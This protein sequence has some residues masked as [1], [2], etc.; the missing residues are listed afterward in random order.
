MS[1]N[2]FEN[3]LNS[4]DYVV[5]PELIA[6]APASPRDSA[7][8]LVYNRKEDKISYDT[9]LNLAKFLPKGAVLVFNETKVIPA[10]FEAMKES[11]GKVRI[12]YISSEDNLSSMN[13]T[14]FERQAN[15]PE[16]TTGGEG[17]PHRNRGQL[18]CL[19]TKSRKN[20][21]IKVMADR[22]MSV[23]SKV[24]IN[25][26]I[27]FTA[28]KQEGKYYFL[29]PS[30]PLN[31]L[32]KV[33]EKYGQAPLPPYIK[34]SPLGKKGLKE[35]YQA[36]FARRNGSVAAPTASLHFT[37]RLMQ[38]IKNSGFDIRFITL[39]VNLGTFAPL[40]EKNIK[41]KK[42]HE[43]YYEIDQKTADFL[44]QAKNKGRPMIAVGTTVARALESASNIK[45][46]LKDL[47]GITDI[48]IQPGYQ[49]KFIDGIITNFHVPRS[50]LLML[51]AAF[52]GRK[53][54]FDLYQKSI[55]KKF[56]F[57]SFGDGMM[58]R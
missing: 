5:P 48:F 24:F 47:S 54:L 58:I 2:S 46:V 55:I 6:Q 41:D 20:N 17:G 22:K 51:V 13:L 40:E 44:N 4:Y 57:F 27:F 23:G 16:S 45:S 31:D 28:V 1:K 32:Y 3:L 39:H 33:L 49:F 26:K 56:K 7:R 37:E 34:H 14:V 19:K 53:K 15:L 30:F 8:L 18:A 21:L 52:V 25:K 38:K 10:R 29:H 12:L 11:G 50:S 43:E 9:F 42:L 35:K 36:V